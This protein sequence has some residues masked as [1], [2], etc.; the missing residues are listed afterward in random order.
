VSQTLA[1]A[2]NIPWHFHIPY[3]P[4]SSGKVERTNRSLKSILTKMSQELHL[5][6]VNGLPP[7][8]LNGK[9]L[10]SSY[11][12]HIRHWTLGCAEIK[13]TFSKHTGS[14]DSNCDTHLGA[15]M[16]LG[17][18]P[19]AA[20]KGSPEFLESSV[21]QVLE[22][23]RPV[24]KF[25]PASRSLQFVKSQCSEEFSQLP[26]IVYLVLNALLFVLASSLDLLYQTYLPLLR[27][28]CG[29]ASGSC[30]RSRA[31][32]VAPGT[33]LEKHLL[34]CCSGYQEIAS[35]LLLPSCEL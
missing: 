34:Q 26:C 21:G 27:H 29:L 24:C 10:S 17:A 16:H 6:W 28:C 32:S 30:R 8:L 19:G 25:S 4:Q 18:N 3:R 15:D 33:R 35:Q 2:L 22:M 1:K 31:L 9:D 13:S 7:S 11:P 5:D 14:Y 23:L 20:A 12:H